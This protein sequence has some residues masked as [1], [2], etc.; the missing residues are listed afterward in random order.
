MEF[1]INFGKKQALK[2][3]LN[4]GA[5]KAIEQAG[6]RY[7]KGCGL[8]L[9]SPPSV[10]TLLNSTTNAGV[11]ELVVEAILRAGGN[12]EFDVDALLESYVENVADITTLRAEINEAYNQTVAPRAALKRAE[13]M[14]EKEELEAAVQAAEKD[15][16]IAEMRAKAAEERTAATKAK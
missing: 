6:A 15:A 10:E 9:R 5:M 4:F 16:A 12:K 8:P 2:A 11:L 3:R 7:L 14:V 13:E 1:E